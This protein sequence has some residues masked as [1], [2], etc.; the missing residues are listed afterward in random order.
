MAR[1]APAPNQSATGT[2]P[3]IELA[4][5]LLQA[6]NEPERVEAA[7]VYR[8]C[9]KQAAKELVEGLLNGRI[10]NPPSDC[11]EHAAND[12]AT[13]PAPYVLA[14][15]LVVLSVTVAIAAAGRRIYLI[16]LIG[17]L[18]ISC[19]GL[20]ALIGPKRRRLSTALCLLLIVLA[21][22][23]ARFLHLPP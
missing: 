2:P 3:D 15:G 17:G 8:G 22:A 7:L 14:L 23:A 13:L 21:T 1:P 11:D 12:W 6:H 16:G 20:Q 18:L 4:I 9:T 10:K 5:R 19:A